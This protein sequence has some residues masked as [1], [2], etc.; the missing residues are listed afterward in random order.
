MNLTLKR[1][2]QSRAQAGMTQAGMTMV[3]LLVAIMILMV[4][5]LAV[6]KLVP[7]AMKTNLRAR[8]DNTALVLAEQQLSLLTSQDLKVGNPL[9][10]IDYVYVA[11]FGSQIALQ[12]PPG[13]FNIGVRHGTANLAV[14]TSLATGFTDKGPVLVLGTLNIDW[15]AG[16]VA[17]YS[18][19]YTAPDGYQYETRWNV[20][21]F[22]ENLNG[23]IQP[24]GKRI[25]LATRGGPPCVAYR[26][27]GDCA[28]GPGVGDF[29]VTLVTTVSWGR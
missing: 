5:V 25:V 11:P 10:G 29:P 20:R 16:A 12:Y 14:G 19:T 9:P 3:E 18:N 21:T 2:V 28:S 24:V 22:F 17:G 1:S 26:E 4:G 7:V 23:T 6:A 15:P 13:I 8:Y 27:G